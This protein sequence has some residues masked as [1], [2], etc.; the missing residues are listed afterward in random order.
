MG[1]G[2][3]FRPLASVDRGIAATTWAQ[4]G[5]GTIEFDTRD[6]VYG[7]HDNGV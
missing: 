6:E 1:I 4:A 5:V 3:Q 2:S 7:D